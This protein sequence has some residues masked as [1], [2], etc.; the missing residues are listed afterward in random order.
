[1]A[2]NNKILIAVDDSETS[3]KAVTYVG[4][5]AGCR[6][7][8]TYCLLHVYP[9]PPPQQFREGFSMSDYKKEREAIGAKVFKE[10]IKILNDQGISTD[11][12]ATVCRMATSGETTS[13]M[14]LA[15][16]QEGDFGTVVMGK[17]GVSKAEEFLFGSISN[18]IVRQSKDFAVWVVG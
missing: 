11:N 6:D 9:V 5:I 13:K 2:D 3:K 8:L 15:V 17:R 1:M 12:I 16:Q 18:T 10:S 14:I 4:R 7:G